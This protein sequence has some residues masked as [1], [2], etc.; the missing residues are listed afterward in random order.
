MESYS[1]R[2]SSPTR[3]AYARQRIHE[4]ERSSGYDVRPEMAPADIGAAMDDLLHRA[5]REQ[6]PAVAQVDSSLFSGFTDYTSSVDD[7][8]AK[9][10]LSV[11]DW[12]EPFRKRMVDG[13]TAMGLPFTTDVRA[14]F[15]R[16]DLLDGPP[17][18]FDEVMSA[19]RTLGEKGKTF[20]F[21]AGPGEG[22]LSCTVW[23]AY[24][25]AGHGILT[26]DGEPGF[27][28]GAAYDA[29]LAV[30]EHVKDCLDA[31]VASESVTSYGLEDDMLKEIAT[32][33]VGMFVGGSWQATELEER[34]PGFTDRW[35]VA[36]VPNAEGR[37]FAT[38]SGGW[39]WA[40]FAENPDVLDAATR[41]VI[42]GWVS[43]EGMAGW[44]NVGGYL[45]PRPSVFDHPSYEGN[46]FTPHFRRFLTHFARQRPDDPAYP[47][48]SEAMQT[49]V[50]KV[51]SGVA[52]PKRALDQALV[53][54]G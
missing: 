14:L 4:Y 54:I 37:D 43:D 1:L 53:E 8:L 50:A 6:A 19:G 46:A 25:A 30:L 44:C 22:A 29:M 35:G 45:P 52:T 23:P 47:K 41:F 32:G 7:A 10:G 5:M 12:A 16:K 13:G 48:V 42:D 49:A 27:A 17:A 2:S 18:S 20:L 3:A 26:D 9:A 39:L 24:W 51:S 11:H 36:P 28:S 40:A 15:Y 31:G 38:L 21:P 33:E 34:M